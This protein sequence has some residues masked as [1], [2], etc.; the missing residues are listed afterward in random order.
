[1]V[2][3]ASGPQSKQKTSYH[4]YVFW[5]FHGLQ[6][7]FFNGNYNLEVN[8]SCAESLPARKWDPDNEGDLFLMRDFSTIYREKSEGSFTEKKLKLRTAF[9]MFPLRLTPEKSGDVPHVK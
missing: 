6:I 3:L 4:G 2:V 1:M 8:E 9:S 7:C 5:F